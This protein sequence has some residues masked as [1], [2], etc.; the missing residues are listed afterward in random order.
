MLA[1]TVSCKHGRGPQS[2]EV[3]GFGPLF[4]F[5]LP[6]PRYTAAAGREMSTAVEAAQSWFEEQRLE[7][8][9]DVL[10]QIMATDNPP[11]SCGTPGTRKPGKQRLRVSL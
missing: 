2:C 4:T 5:P 9:L 6:I 3:V 11:Y 1:L 8:F 10:R 7:D